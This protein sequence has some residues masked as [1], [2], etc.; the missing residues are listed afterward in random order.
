MNATGLPVNLPADQRSTER[1]FNTEAF[2][3]QPN[4]TIGNAGRNVILGPSQHMFDG[5]AHKSVR[6]REGHELTFRFEAFNAANHPVWGNP[7]AGWGSSTL[8]TT[9]TRGAQANFGKIRS[10]AVS[11]RQVQLGLK[12]TF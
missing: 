9:A 5:T 7:T 1:W 10:T 8:N 6:I 11:M 3:L 4:G 2:V 12:Y